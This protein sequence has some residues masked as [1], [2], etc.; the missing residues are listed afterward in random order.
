PG[1]APGLG[2]MP[3]SCLILAS[4]LQM[5]YAVPAVLSD[6]MGQ[7]APGQLTFLILVLSAP[8]WILTNGLPDTAVILSGIGAASLVVAAVLVGCGTFPKILNGIKSILP[9]ASTMNDGFIV[10]F[11]LYGF[12]RLILLALENV[13][14]NEQLLAQTLLPLPYITGLLNLS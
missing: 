14:D 1:A 10:L 11:A 4:V 3:Q 7:D 13:T 2:T 12:G 9:S 6:A 8:I 5:F